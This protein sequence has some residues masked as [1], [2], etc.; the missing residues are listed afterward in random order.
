MLEQGVFTEEMVYK[1][2]KEW[3]E[4]VYAINIDVK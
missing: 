4:K 1:I 3:P 2:H